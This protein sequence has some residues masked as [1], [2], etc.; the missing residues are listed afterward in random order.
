MFFIG[1][2]ILRMEHDRTMNWS[3][4]RPGEIPYGAEMPSPSCL[5]ALLRAAALAGALAIAAR[6]SAGPQ[7]APADPPPAGSLHDSAASNHASAASPS[8]AADAPVRM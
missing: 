4:L 7:S 3:Y 6:A 8:T 1:M 2:T 5:A